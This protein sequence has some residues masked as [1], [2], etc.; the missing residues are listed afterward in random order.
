VR[1]V[2]ALIDREQNPIDGRS[3]AI[4]ELREQCVRL[5]AISFPPAGR[6]AVLAR[7]TS[8]AIVTASAVEHKRGSS[9]STPGNAFDF[10][11]G[12]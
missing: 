1:H 9:R 3:I 11:V 6:R 5:S 8:F 2:N 12:M 4:G 7:S 10:S